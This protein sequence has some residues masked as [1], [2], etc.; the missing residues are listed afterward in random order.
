MLISLLRGILLAKDPEN[1]YLLSP[2][3][4]QHRVRVG[5]FENKKKEREQAK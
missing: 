1:E 4:G 2:G 3:K 5:F